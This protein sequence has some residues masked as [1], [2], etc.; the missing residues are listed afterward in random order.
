M[1]GH[2]VLGS[3]PRKVIVANDWICDTSTW[4][5]ARAVLDRAAF[6]WVFADL[7]GYGRS[8]GRGGE[9]TL[10]EA[11]GDVL[12]LAD[13]LGFARFSFV[14]HSMSTLIAFHL[15]QHSPERI[16]S[17]VALTPVP[18]E[19]F[20]LD[21]ATLEKLRAIARG[22]DAKRT[23]WLRWRLGARMSEGWARF[24][25]ERW[26]ACADP[27]AVAGYAAM[28]A[29]RGLPEPTARIGCP[30]LAVTGE[31]DIEQM[32]REAAMKLLAPLC[33][34]LTVTSL[35]ECGHY[36][37]QEMPPLLVAIVE[38]FLASAIKT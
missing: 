30:L 1:L 35:A 34:R 23:R 16:E 20:G 11:A 18:P 9:F 8:M 24:K 6:T 17:A 15:A 27:E 14:G 2:A 36:P 13:A 4:D 26:R 12:A 19:G 28:F 22:D 29:R 32:R 25:A 3:G 37:M 31:E 21:E 10:L 5:A 7:R 33:D 38:G